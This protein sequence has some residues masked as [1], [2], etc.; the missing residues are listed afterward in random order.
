MDSI[1]LMFNILISLG[2]NEMTDLLDKGFKKLL[3]KYKTPRDWKKLFL[4]LK[5]FTKNENIREDL[6]NKF[7]EAFSKKNLKRLA[8][9]TKDISGYDFKMKLSEILVYLMTSVDIPI[10]LAEEYSKAIIFQ[11]MEELKTL[12]PEKFREV[13]YEETKNEFNTMLLEII[14]KIEK[15]TNQLEVFLKEDI[16]VFSA[17]QIDLRLKQ[18]TSNPSIGLEYFKV[19][20]FKFKEDFKEKIN[21]DVIIVKGFN[22]KE[23]AY[24]VIN[25]LLFLEEVR[26]IYVVENSDSWKRL[27]KS[28]VEGNIFIP[29]F[30]EEKIEAI[31]NNTTIFILSEHTPVF[32]KEFME[33]RP[34]TIS[35]LSE[36]LRNAGADFKRAN[37]LLN[38]THGLFSQIE[39]HIF[40]GIDDSQPS[41]KKKVSQRA[42][43]TC[44]LLG[45]WEEVEGDKLIV[46]SLYD[47]NYDSFLEEINPYINNEDPLICKTKEYGR[48]FYYLPSVE[49]IWS[50]YGINNN[51]FL[52]LF[53]ENNKQIWGL[54]LNNFD[55]ILTE[56][57]KLLT[58]D[59]YE[60]M[61][62]QIRGEKLFWSETI[63][64]G[65]LQTLMEMSK[66]CTNY[67]SQKILDE[68]IS[69][70][71]QKIQNED[72]WK[73]ISNFWTD[74]CEISPEVTLSRL[75]KEV[76]DRASI[77]FMIKDQSQGSVF[78]K[79]SYVSII[80]GFEQFLCQKKYFWR[81]YR[82]LL[83]IDSFNFSYSTNSP[84]DTI[85]KVLCTW[86]NSSVLKNAKEKIKAAKIALEISP[87]NAWEYI[88]LSV[89][90][91]ENNY[92]IDLIHPKYREYENSSS[93]IN[94]EM[95]KTNK[96]YLKLLMDNIDN[97]RDSW[98]KL[99]DLSVEMNKEL[100]EEVFSKLLNNLNKINENDELLIKNN[101]RKTINTHRYFKY[102]EWA[103]PDEDL[104]L[105]NALLNKIHL[106]HV[107]YEYNYLFL[108][109]IWYPQNNII[110]FR[111][112]EDGKINDARKDE[113]IRK[114]IEEF[115]EHNY[116]LKILASS[117]S[118]YS[119]NILGYYLSQYWNYGEWNYATFKE[120]LSVHG[121]ENIAL[122][123]MAGTECK[124]KLPYFEI[125]EDLTRLGYSKEII[126]AIYRIEAEN[127]ENIPLIDKESDSVK[128]LFWKY[129]I[130][131]DENNTQ[132]AIKEC[133]KYGSLDSFLVQLYMLYYNKKIS[134]EQIYENLLSIDKSPYY[135]ESIS[136]SSMVKYYVQQLVKA[137]QE[138]YLSDSEK[139]IEIAEIELY[140]CSLLEWDEMKC[141]QICLKQ[142]P[143]LFA[144]IIKVIYKK[145]NETNVDITNNE[146]F[147]R[148]MYR[149][150]R[151]AH[152]CPAEKD[153]KVDEVELEKWILEFRQLLIT[154]NQESLFTLALGR[155][156]S[157]SPVG[158]D[159]H[160]PCE[161]VRNMIE[162]Y[163]DDEMNNSYITEVCNRR[164]VY[165][166]TAGEDEFK[167]A[168]AFKENGEYLESEHPETAKIYFGLYNIYMQD[169]ERERRAAGRLV[170]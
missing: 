113:F 1:E 153:G 96:G 65:M 129:R 142:S 87:I 61:N 154:N 33:L 31:P 36:C 38:D 136:T 5:A 125:I 29:L 166:L 66:L 88:Y 106:E 139:I 19:D 3:V 89:D 72:D 69:N 138:K 170:L 98:N 80:N 41:W 118:V 15:L 90:P 25:E 119:E 107:E 158:T 108:N 83:K 44:L 141:L 76:D 68:I 28:K 95:I 67:K 132:W 163:G 30:H 146:D 78:E 93:A 151:K 40:T 161:S 50:Y 101:I 26:P 64:R 137:I 57:E 91:R 169:S 16:N 9:D 116:D 24:C 45:A 126:T 75:E 39:K 13:Y 51:E 73:Y 59:V 97:S 164:G 85:K 144:D 156:F 46:E 8:K 167:I 6:I 148:S 109:D 17:G 92:F 43:S 131:L 32:N 58:C 47:N 7:E 104:E 53:I 114:K 37:Y 12:Y 100:K 4:N 124:E 42:I 74:L 52:E 11:M 162:K 120:L 99:I 81:A 71:L 134:V 82:C 27:I 112:E 123:Y 122:V 115:Q 159:G 60:M 35:T 77:L 49:N 103:M 102:S 168:N 117:I 54:F 121:K 21:E 157:F 62:A 105:Y 143:K 20:D 14:D 94:D 18:N 70:V 34:R 86:M 55:L 111:E 48:V 135:L 145:D 10:E 127:T 23:T 155:L 2:A 150:Y 133:K 147:N 22:R 56:P 128:I 130:N 63:R 79:S 149:L 140:F 110:P 160:E 152:F 84:K 165:N